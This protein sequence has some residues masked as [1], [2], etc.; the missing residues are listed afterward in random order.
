[1]SA[2]PVGRHNHAVKTLV[3]KYG[4]TSV[5][6]TERIQ[7]VAARIAGARDQGLRVVVVVSAMGDTTDDL[8]ALAREIAPVPPPRELDML[9]TAGER[10]SMAL[11]SIALQ[12]RDC[13]AI[14]F[15]GSQSGIITDNRHADAKILDVRCDRIRAAL[16]SERV[17][18]VAGFQGVSAERE[19]T[20]LGRG[21]SDT[22]AVALAAA[23]GAERCEIYTDVDGVYSA[24]PRLVPQAVKI[25]R[26]DYDEMLELASRGARVL[27]PRSVEVARRFGVPVHV[28]SSYNYS[29]GTVVQAMERIEP[30]S[31]RGIASDEDVTAFTIDGLPAPGADGALLLSALGA[32]GIRTALVVHAHDAPAWTTIVARD[33]AARADGILR[34]FA[35][36]RG[37]RLRQDDDIALLTAVGHAVHSH[38]GTVG[39]VLEALAA[40]GVTVRLVASSALSV[41]CV[42]PRSE[43]R[44][45]A[46]LL[47]DKLGLAPTATTPAG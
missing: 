7:A 20:T 41:T 3:Q 36:E 8:L 28:R 2:D 11:L 37:A 18:I 21:G 29:S 4:G 44:R 16:D 43:V 40:G 26:L 9:L 15:T 23:L 6:T 17:V 32:A 13:A 34:P 46:A 35:A 1:M 5:A 30:E 38:P 14:S 47:H 27:H 10:I 12:A 24:D 33:D 31:V 22:T 19:I 39:R 42:V 25:E 45:A